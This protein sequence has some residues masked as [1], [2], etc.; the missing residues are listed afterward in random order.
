MRMY[1]VI[2]FLMLAS[3]AQADYIVS[4]RVFVGSTEAENSFY[5]NAQLYAALGP[6]ADDQNAISYGSAVDK[7]S[8]ANGVVSTG[9]VVTTPYDGD[10]KFFVALYDYS[11]VLLGY[12]ALIKWSDLVTAGSSSGGVFPVPLDP[13]YWNAGSSY[14][15]VPEPTSIGLLAIGM[16]ALLLRRRRR[17]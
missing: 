11:D 9:T 15:A 4:W 12:S 1:L 7:D 6:T 2:V 5:K 17:T 13:T 14:T 3:I 8:D 10:L 16:S